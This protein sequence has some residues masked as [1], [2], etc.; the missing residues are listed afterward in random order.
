MFKKLA[1]SAAFGLVAAA[2]GAT[3]LGVGAFAL[4]AFLKNNT[5]LGQSGAAAVIALLFAIVAVIA[6]MMLR[7]GA[8]PK[9]H[10]SPAPSASSGLP[11]NVSELRERALTIVKERPLIAGAAGV[12]G[13][14]YVLRNPAIVTALVGALAGRAEG[15]AEERRNSFF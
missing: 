10:E 6:L 8:K 13:A 7:G 4:Y 9:A 5:A 12:V 3:A 11:V 1:R 14:L 2:A 15:K